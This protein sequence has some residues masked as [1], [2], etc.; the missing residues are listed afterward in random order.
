MTYLIRK[1][2][3]EMRM[4]DSRGGKYQKRIISQKLR[5][6]RV[7]RNKALTEIWKML[8]MFSNFK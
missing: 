7:L 4:K 3:K 6:K 2:S 1:H 5:E 8:N